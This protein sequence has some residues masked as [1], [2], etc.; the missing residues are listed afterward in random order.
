MITDSPILLSAFYANDDVLGDEFDTLVTKVFNSYNSM[1]VF[2]DRV[3]PYNP[4]GRFQT[5]KE[6][7]D[8]SR[9]MRRFL[10]EHGVVCRYYSGDI[11][12]YDVLVSDIINNL[13]GTH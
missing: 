12:G 7:D 11:S 10:S 13:K 1:N 8:V 3:K 6:S 4:A 2:I 5:E 9:D